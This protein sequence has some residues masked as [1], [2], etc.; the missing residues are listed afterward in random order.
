MKMLVD[1]VLK[2]LRCRRGN[3]MIEFAIGA[4]FF[5]PLTISSSDGWF[6]RLHKK[7]TKPAN[8]P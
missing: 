7:G 8:S 5:K 6:C 4:S 1:S 3:I 2:I